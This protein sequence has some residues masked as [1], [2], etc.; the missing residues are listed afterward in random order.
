MTTPLGISTHNMKF[1]SHS[2]LPMH[3]AVSQENEGFPHAT[4]TYKYDKY[5]V[6]CTFHMSRCHLRCF[7]ILY[8]IELHVGCITGCDHMQMHNILSVSF[9]HC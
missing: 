6:S 9:C 3:S 1:L 2:V 5:R 4:S 8:D 7:I